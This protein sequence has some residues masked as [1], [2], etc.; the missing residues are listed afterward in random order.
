ML[1]MQAVIKEENK[2]KFIVCYRIYFKI[3]WDA[4]NFLK[5]GNCIITIVL[6]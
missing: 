4:V 6:Y 1:N 3:S 5:V 2:K